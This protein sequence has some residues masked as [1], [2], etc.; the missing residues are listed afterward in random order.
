VA[1][2]EDIKLARPDLAGVPAR[3]RSQQYLGVK[4]TYRVELANGRLLNV[5]LHGDHR[6][7]F[8]N[9]MQVHLAFDPHKTLVLA[10]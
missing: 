3:I 2:P 1:R 8:D 9:G 10:S 5:D 7:G 6:R 4:T